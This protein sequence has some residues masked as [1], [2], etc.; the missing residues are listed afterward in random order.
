MNDRPAATEATQATFDR[1]EVIEGI[2]Q[3]N[4]TAEASFLAQFNTEALA[5]YL[6]HLRNAKH[7]HV[8]L[9]GW[10]QRR[11]EKMNKS[12]QGLRRAG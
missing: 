2:R 4:P 8:R 9:A 6:E 1:N 3:Y 5:D 12:R 10:V 11:A 7:K